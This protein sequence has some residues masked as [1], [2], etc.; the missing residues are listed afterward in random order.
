MYFLETKELVKQYA[1]RLALN[2]VSIRIPSGSIF[3]LAGPNGAGK[4]TLLRIL[5]GILFPDSGKI[6]FRKQASAGAGGV[7]TGYLPEERGL[8]A[9]MRIGEQALYLSR[10][11]GASSGEAKLRVDRWFSRLGLLPLRERRAEELSKGLQQR[12]QFAVAVLHDPDFLVFDEPFDGLDPA[13]TELLKNEVLRLKGQGK[14]IVFSTHNMSHVE[15]LCDEIALID[16]GEVVLSGNVC[17]LCNQPGRQIFKICAAN[18]QLIAGNV[19][20]EVLS[21][22]KVAGNS[23]FRVRKPPETSRNE[24]LV[25]LLA[26][27]DIISFEEEAVSL[28]DLFLS[29]TH[30]P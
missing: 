24:F 12:V 6:S 27:N 15:E 3:G 22:E 9:K 16:K 23:R 11:K 29:V 21:S 2:K 28:R 30:H 4:T 18:E 10:L 25:S 14:T 1:G 26:H 7:K 5:A 20:Y 17:L 8:Y 13:G 19:R